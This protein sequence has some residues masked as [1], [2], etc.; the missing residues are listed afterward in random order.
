MTAS[1]QRTHDLLVAARA[2]IEDPAG[3]TKGVMARSSLGDSVMP[4]SPKASCFCT[5]GALHAAGMDPNARDFTHDPAVTL[6]ADLIPGKPRPFPV[7][8]LTTFNDEPLTTHV[9][10]LNLFDRAIAVAKGRL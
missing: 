8:A 7:E 4:N 5:V 2:K 10:V 6:L 3:W 9:D 1:A